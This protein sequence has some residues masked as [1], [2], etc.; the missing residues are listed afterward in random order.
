M[1]TS[2]GPADEVAFRPSDRVSRL[3]SWIKVPT[4]LDGA[5]SVF[6]VFGSDDALMMV[7]G[8]NLESYEAARRAC[9]AA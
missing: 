1:S 8:L 6:D 2:C 3:P 7:D 5:C 4:A 9:L